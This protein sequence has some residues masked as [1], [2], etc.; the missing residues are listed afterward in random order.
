[1]DENP[2]RAPEE[3]LTPPSMPLRLSTVL[4]LTAILAWGMACDPILVTRQ[5][6]RWRD[7]KDGQFDRLLFSRQ[8]REDPSRPGV[9]TDIV[10]ETWISINK[11]LAWPALA[12]V[13]FLAWKAVWAVAERRRRQPTASE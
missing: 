1:M 4:I 10:D 5:T 6:I 2:Y 12:L 9:H 8:I 13:A 3:D 11:S 7:A